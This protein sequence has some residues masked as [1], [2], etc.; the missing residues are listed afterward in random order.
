MNVQKEELGNCQVQLTVEVN[1]NRL[2]EAMQAAAR[3]Y[4]KRV[5]IPGFRRGKAPPRMVAQAVG[6][7]VL[8]EDALTEILPKVVREA[9]E[10]AG[11][12]VY[13][14]DHVEINLEQ[15]DPPTFRMLIPTPPVVKLGDMGYIQVEEKEVSVEEQRV[16]ELLGAL[17][18]ERVR[19][20]PSLGPAAYGDRA[21][22][23]LRGDLMDGTT[24]ED[25]KGVEVTL[26][27]RNE[28]AEEG[29]EEEPRPQ[30]D[31]IDV[32]VGMMVNQ[33][34]EVPVVY[35]Q[36]W[37]EKRLQ[38]RT[39]LYKITLL[40]LK[41]LREP[42]LDDEFAQEVGEF[43][44]LDALRERVRTNLLA[45][46]EDQAFNRQIESVLDGLVDESE[47]EYPNFLVQ[48]EVE[49]RIESLE[50]QLKS[51]GLELEN[52]FEMVGQTR[53]ELEDD[54]WDE[55]EEFVR[56]SLVLG[57]FIR[58]NDITVTDE[59]VER[60]L[61]LILSRYE[62]AVAET[63]R[64]RIRERE[65]DISEVLNRLISRKALYE[66]YHVVTGEERPSLFPE[67]DSES[68]QPDAE[69][70]A[71]E[72]SM[73][74]AVDPGMFGVDTTSLSD[75]DGVEKWIADSEPE[76]DDEATEA[77]SVVITVANDRSS[78]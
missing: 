6:E 16:D 2:D 27:D 54:L 52:Y 41:K 38:G 62:P 24:V 36:E 72:T 64:E 14:P 7:D 44:T 15:M 49:R 78:E 23:D 35:P 30:P 65:Q 43:D 45:E 56:R 51:Y 37:P 9:V 71:R 53:A 11:V 17:R 50:R 66:L 48:H 29:M 5:N 68:E 18:K 34:K 75:T 21:T 26:F 13:S 33:V 63:L 1:D 10:Q 31:L 76:G 58:Q 55:A 69:D 8:L 12:E 46:A 47:L 67:V 61:D 77:P 59:E 57:E 25:Q 3:R 4:A 22:I 42:E 60:E 39:V 19:L 28:F 74:S 32:M 20:E 70:A 73:D 40:D